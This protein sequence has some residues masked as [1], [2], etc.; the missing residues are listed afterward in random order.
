MDT[1]ATG[2]INVFLGGLTWWVIES[3][4]STETSKSR[5]LLQCGVFLP[6]AKWYHQTAS[7][8]SEW[9]YSLI[10]IICVGELGQHWFSYGLSPVRGQSIIW[11][12]AGLLSIGHIG[13]NFSE[14]WNRILSFAFTEMHL[15]MSPAKMTAIL[16]RVRWGNPSGDEAGMFQVNQA[17]ITTVDVMV[18]C[19]TTSSTPL[20]LTV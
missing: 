6:V 7:M 15:K 14:I 9:W 4:N 18:P 2:L 8:Y 17:N 19:I 12:N 5:S 13:I 20:V 11:T 10:F 3:I 16:S 1:P